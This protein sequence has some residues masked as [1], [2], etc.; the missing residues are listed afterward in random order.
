MARPF[1]RGRPVVGGASANYERLQ[2]KYR[3]AEPSR[4]VPLPSPARSADAS[5][6]STELGTSRR[7][8]SIWP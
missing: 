3:Y 1:G 4:L 5:R 8:R 7:P 6:A 2:K